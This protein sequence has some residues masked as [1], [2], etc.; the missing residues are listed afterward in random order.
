M[1]AFAKAMIDA[2]KA[3]EKD[4]YFNM[5]VDGGEFHPFP[6]RDFLFLREEEERLLS[7]A[8]AKYDAPRTLDIGC[9]IGRHMRFVRKLRESSDLLGVELSSAL[10]N[11]C[12]KLL[13]GARFVSWLEEIPNG[14]ESDVVILL[15]NSVG[16]FA[17]ERKTYEA[18]LQ[19]REILVD[20]GF[21]LI[22]C[23]NPFSRGFNTKNQEIE[24]NG[25]L[26][27]PFPWGYASQSWMKDKLLR[28][29]FAIED[30]IEAS[31]PGFSIF[32]VGKQENA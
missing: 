3:A 24:Y 14:E 17:T 18:I 15:G 20:G 22:D 4:V 30:T 6:C 13:P 7:N 1:E 21:L 5:R 29:G 28:A 25:L 16:L 19:I 26:D 27:G 10:R 31:I 9:C 23:G 11:Q 2:V 8:V 12:A 32:S